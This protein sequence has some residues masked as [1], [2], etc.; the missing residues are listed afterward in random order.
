MPV[1]VRPMTLDDVP[2]IGRVQLAA[3]DDLDRRTGQTPREITDATRERVHARLIHFVTHDPGGAWVAANDREL[4]GCALAL[5]RESL[6]GLS[7]LVVDPATQSTGAGRA[8]LDASLTYAAGTDRAVILS[9]EDTR[10]IRVYGTSGFALH[11]QVQATGT[12]DRSRLP[13]LGGRVRPGS[14]AD[15]DLAEAIDRAVRGAA[16]GPD[17]AL[18]AASYRM[19]MVDDV[20]GCGY[21][22]L[23]ADGDVAALAASDDTTATVLL[24]RALAHAS[25]TDTPVTVS[26]ITAGQQWA[27]S[28]AFHARLRVAPGGPVFWRGIEPPAAYLPSGAYL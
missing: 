1:T 18:L 26:A 5:R 22:Y 3:F 13:A 16:R 15:V 9:T 25:D 20:D 11:P 2:A 21:V 10:A 8:L 17:Q 28:A 14:L 12:P 27:I 23:R 24:W 6:W 4:V 19:F 7:L